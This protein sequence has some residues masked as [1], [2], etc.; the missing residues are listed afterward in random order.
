MILDFNINDININLIINKSK[1][2]PNART[3]CPTLSRSQSLITVDTI[4]TIDERAV[5]CHA[6]PLRDYVIQFAT[7][8]RSFGALS[9]GGRVLALLVVGEQAFA[10]S[11]RRRTASH[12]VVDGPQ[13]F[14]WTAL[15]P[16]RHWSVGRRREV[17]RLQWRD[18]ERESI[19]YFSVRRHRVGVQSRQRREW[20]RFLNNKHNQRD[21]N[22]KRLLPK[23]WA[24]TSICI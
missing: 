22:T 11:L 5:R 7:H 20:R 24:Q 14:G 3:L 9:F 8:D 2:D 1:H 17:C 12:H 13:V 18:I 23:C 4:I 10:H 15:E 19:R 16:I 6:L 21:V